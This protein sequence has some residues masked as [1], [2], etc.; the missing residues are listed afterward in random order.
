MKDPERQRTIQPRPLR[1]H[2][3]RPVGRRHRTRLTAQAA[4][5]QGRLFG[6][7]EAFLGGRVIRLVGGN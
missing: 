3:A 7:F 1:H 2:R 5:Q 4:C 6:R